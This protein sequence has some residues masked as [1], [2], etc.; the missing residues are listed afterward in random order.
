[1]PAYRFGPQHI[2]INWKTWRRWG[3][4]W[5]ALAR[6]TRRQVRIRPARGWRGSPSWKG[7]GSGRPTAI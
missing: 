4:G 6:E 7:T 1:L 2:R 3:G 5:P